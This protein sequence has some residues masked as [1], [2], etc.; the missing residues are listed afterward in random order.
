MLHACKHWCYIVVHPCRAAPGRPHPLVHLPMPVPPLHA[1]VRH[2]PPYAVHPKV[3]CSCASMSRSTG[4]ASSTGASPYAPIFL[5]ALGTQKCNVCMCA[6]MS[7][8]TGWASSISWPRCLS[9]QSLCPS[10][11]W[12]PSRCVC[13]CACVCACVCVCVC[14]CMCAVQGSRGE[15]AGGRGEGGSMD[16]L[17]GGK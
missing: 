2:A 9:T 7:R 3:L 14:V 5:C 1:C 10:T 4:W 13:V 15:E 8:R 11:A 6:C 17:C 16:V 12:W